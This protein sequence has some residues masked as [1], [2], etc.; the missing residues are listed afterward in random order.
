MIQINEGL[1]Y[2]KTG[3]GVNDKQLCYPRTSWH[4]VVEKPSWLDSDTKPSYAWDEISD[5]PTI[6]DASKFLPLSGGTMTG[7]LVINKAGSAQ[8]DTAAGHIALQKDGTDYAHI[9]P[10]A[11]NSNLAIESKGGIILYGG[12]SDNGTAFSSANYVAV[13]SGSLRGVGTVDLTGFRN[14]GLSGT[15]SHGSVTLTL[16]SKTGTI[17]LEEDIPDS[18]KFVTTDTEQTIS[19]EKLFSKGTNGN[20]HTTIRIMPYNGASPTRAYGVE[21][22][23]NGK[24]VTYGTSGISISENEEK[25]SLLFP[26]ADGTLALKEDIPDLSKLVTTD[27]AQTISGAKT[28]TKGIVLQQKVLT[29]TQSITISPIHIVYQSATSTGIVRTERTYTFPDKDGQLAVT[30]DLADYATLDTEQRITGKKTFNAGSFSANMGSGRFRSLQGRNGMAMMYEATSTPNGFILETDNAGTDMAHFRNATMSSNEI[31]AGSIVVRIPKKSG[32]VALT[33]DIPDSS[34]FVTTDT[35]QTI[36]GIKTFIGSGTSSYADQIISIVPYAG[37]SPAMGS[38]GIMFKDVN[39]TIT[40]VYDGSR[41]ISFAGGKAAHAHNFPNDKSGTIAL[42][43]DLP[44]ERIVI[45]VK[46]L[47]WVNSYTTEEGWEYQAIRAK[48]E[49]LSGRDL[50]QP[51]D[52]IVLAQLRKRI[53]TTPRR[54]CYKY[55]AD[56]FIYAKD[57]PD[58]DIVTFVDLSG[59]FNHTNAGSYYADDLRGLLTASSA[60][61]VIYIVRHDPEDT[62]NA[63]WYHVSNSVSFRLLYNSSKDTASFV[64]EGGA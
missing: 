9:R 54:E 58:D 36:K 44:E 3:P 45:R 50:L 7:R 27:T 14:L 46:W 26:S 29:T 49:F 28:F 5:K 39:G 53:H 43:S 21:I 52:K 32:L 2:E 10:T 33:S 15:I 16:P 61:R 30:A 23:T 25:Y 56:S 42:T 17:A 19:E 38:Y 40:N 31:N 11:S 20:V 4:N 48:I 1:L 22:D 12:A 60:N 63:N 41:H 13:Y 64:I 51:N 18:S 35:P 47:N 62:T 57:L 59:R 8:T 34:K 37:S 55:R 24:T 6:P